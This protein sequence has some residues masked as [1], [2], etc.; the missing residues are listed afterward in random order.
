[1]QLKYRPDKGVV[2][3]LDAPGIGGT[4]LPGQ[5]PKV[6]HTSRSISKLSPE[7]LAATGVGTTEPE[8]TPAYI[9]F[10]RK[11]LCFYAYFQEGVTE[12]RLETYRYRF[13]N[14]YIYIFFIF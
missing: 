6:A 12:A 8:Q 1:M 4:L 14:N 11:V 9:A 3:N 2:V 13:A 7:E 10:D 5:K